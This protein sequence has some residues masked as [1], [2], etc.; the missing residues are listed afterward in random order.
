MK[1]ILVLLIVVLL[2]YS[3]NVSA[4]GLERFIER[5]AGESYEEGDFTEYY[6]LQY[7]KPIPVYRGNYVWDIS[8]DIWNVEKIRN[9]AE[10][11]RLQKNI[12]IRVLL[13]PVVNEYDK[14]C[15]MVKVRITGDKTFAILEV[16]NFDKKGVM[17]NDTVVNNPIYYEMEP[18]SVFEA[19]YDYYWGDG[20]KD[21]Y[22]D[23][24]VSDG[25]GIPGMAYC[26]WGIDYAY[27][28]KNTS[29]NRI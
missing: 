12:W 16:K 1:K 24:R 4:M 3:T 28:W 29:T 18:G 13:S 19:L 11:P 6:G 23:K 2:G 8:M 21:C 25:T 17:Y 26:P 20:L 14:T 22:G 10:K 5:E 9:V 7:W 15:T 27:N